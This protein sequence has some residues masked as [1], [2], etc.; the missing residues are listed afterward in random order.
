MG[1]AQEYCLIKPISRH[2]LKDSVEIHS[3][4]RFLK[5]HVENPPV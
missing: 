3:M 2:A 4:I 1:W 5:C